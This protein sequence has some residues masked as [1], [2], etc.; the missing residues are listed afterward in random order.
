MF[1]H[2]HHSCK[3]ALGTPFAPFEV[4]ESRICELSAYAVDVIDQ[5][6]L[7]LHLYQIMLHVQLCKI[8]GQK[9]L[10]YQEGNTSLFFYVNSICMCMITVR[11]W[12]AKTVKE[13]QLDNFISIKAQK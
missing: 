7:P 13:R 4:S 3:S 8:Q 1:S 6:I 10:N 2:P 12:A 9:G 5:Y 11:N